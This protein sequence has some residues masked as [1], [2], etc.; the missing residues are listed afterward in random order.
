MTLHRGPRNTNPLE[1]VARRRHA[2]LDAQYDLIITVK[3]PHPPRRQMNFC[4][5]CGSEVW[6]LKGG[7]VLTCRR[8]HHWP[9]NP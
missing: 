5:T 7:D 6:E 9:L 3:P 2:E 1:A 4:P 8:G